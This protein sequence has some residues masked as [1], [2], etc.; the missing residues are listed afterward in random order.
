[1]IVIQHNI[2]TLDRSLVGWL[3]TGDGGKQVTVREICPSASTSTCRSANRSSSSSTPSNPSSSAA[4]VNRR[5]HPTSNHS[6]TPSERTRSTCSSCSALPS[7][8]SATRA[9][10][11]TLCDRSAR[12]RLRPYARQLTASDTA[13]VDSGRGRHDRPVRRSAPRVR[14]HRRGRRRRHRHH[15]EPQGRRAHLDLG[16]AGEAAPRRPWSGRR[17]RR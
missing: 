11:A 12:A 2:D 16:R 14:H 9:Q 17:H 13:V 6:R 7:R 8:H 5:T 4:S 15:L 10:P 3:E 1:M